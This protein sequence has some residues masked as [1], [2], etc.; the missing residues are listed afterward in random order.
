M[1][2]VLIFTILGGFFSLILFYILKEFSPFELSKIDE[3]IRMNAILPGEWDKLNVLIQQQ[4]TKGLIFQY[5]SS[6][7]YVAFG[8]ALAAIFSFITALHLFFDKLFFRSYYENPS[9]YNATRR[10]FLIVITLGL[11]FYMKL[12]FL[13]TQT[14]IL[15]PIAALVLEIIIA[16]TINP[17]LRSK[18]TKVQNKVKNTNAK[19]QKPEVKEIVPVRENLE[20]ENS[21]NPEFEE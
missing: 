19:Q 8:V 15:V 11:V 6:T 7:A 3:L 16:T 14:I 21:D 17:F 2:N 5:L 4:I 13:E 12:S 9:V 10:S 1:K 18:L 20:V